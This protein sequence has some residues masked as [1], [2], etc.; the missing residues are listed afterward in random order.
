MRKEATTLYLLIVKL[1][2]LVD[3][4]DLFF[5]KS[6]RGGQDLLVVLFELVILLKKTIV[7][8]FGFYFFVAPQLDIFFA[9]VD[10]ILEFLVDTS[11]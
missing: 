2:L 9:G 1:V 6:E 5:A 7:L 4:F 10:S 3:F 8:H 11:D